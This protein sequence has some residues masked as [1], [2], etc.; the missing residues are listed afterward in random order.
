MKPVRNHLK[1]LA[2]AACFLLAA[3]TGFSDEEKTAAFPF[4]KDITLPERPKDVSVFTIDADIYRATEKIPN[5]IRIVG[6]DGDF[7]PFT[8]SE[9]VQ[10]NQEGTEET[11][12]SATI[13]GFE[14][15]PDG[16]VRISAS[17]MNIGIPDSADPRVV[18]MRIHTKAKDF[19][20]KVKVFDGSG[21]DLIA[22]GAFL[23][24]SSRVNLR[25]DM[26]R[27]PVPTPLRN[28]TRT[29][30]FV[31]VMDNYTEIKDSPLFR[32][33]EGDNNIVEQE[34]FRESPK[35]DGI[36]LQV[37]LKQKR[38]HPVS[39]SS[40][41]E[42]LSREKKGETTV[43]KISNGFAP[44]NSITVDCSDIFF[45]RPYRLYDKSGKLVSSG[46]VRR[47]ETATFR[48]QTSDRVINVPASSRSETWTLELDN[49]AN[50]ELKELEL[51]A[52]G[53]VYQVRFLSMKSA[54]PAASG[55]TSP[56]GYR[57]FY[58]GSGHPMP[59]S[60]FTD[61]LRIAKPAPVPSDSTLSE[62]K[63]NPHYKEKSDI[64]RDWGL[65]YKI[66]MAAAA[67]AVFLILLFSVKKID[68]VE[69]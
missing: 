33:V 27:F 41:V 9:E 42:I 51:H 62:Q 57:V 37:V 48:T 38:V 25:N 15:L 67:L 7:C 34:K 55:E 8:V 31:I 21:N 58:G 39:A 40:P 19:D 30:S 46:T 20:K 28:G 29:F 13:T 45:S 59:S 3:A 68:K 49:G 47:L 36:T 16:S 44:L 23:D 66:I 26:V 65:V 61:A 18:G 43:L 50:A 53:P 60:E 12:C 11:N 2:A 54:A 4:Y 32:V 1:L 6:P 17:L 56:S 63:A 10:L 22:E 64:V 24:Y 52:S 5:D 14:T 35:I 69:D